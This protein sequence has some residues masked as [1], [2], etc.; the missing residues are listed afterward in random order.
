MIMLLKEF[1]EKTLF[2]RTIADITSAYEKLIDDKIRKSTAKTNNSFI[3]IGTN[4]R[5]RKKE[6]YLV[7][8]IVHLIVNTVINY[9]FSKYLIASNNINS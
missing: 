3:S 1:L 5:T 2:K 6:M 8:T 7:L 4:R 9:F